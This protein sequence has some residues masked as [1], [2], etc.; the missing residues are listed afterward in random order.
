[1]ARIRLT[2]TRIDELTCPPEKSQAFVFDET[3]PSLA[4]RVTPSG[5][6]SYVFESKLDRRT[7]RITLGSTK[8]WPLES[9]WTGK[10]KEREEV[11]RGARE[12]AQRLATLVDQGID[13]R[14]V[15]QAKREAKVAAETAAEAA[16]KY[17]LA[18]LFEAYAA[19]IEKA[20]KKGSARTARSLFS[21]HA[22]AK[23]TQTP[24]KDVSADD[25]ADMLRAVVEAGK[26]RTAGALRTYMLAAFNVGMRARFDPLL[27][28]AFKEYGIT[29]N[30]VAAIPAIASREHDR[31]LTNDELKTYVTALGDS[32]RDKALLLA[33]LAGGQ[34][35][36]QVLRIKVTD[37]D[38][39]TKTLRL[40]DPKGRR[41]KARLHLLPLA[42]RAAALVDSLLAG[43]DEDGY[44]LPLDAQTPGKRAKAICMEA[45]IAP[46]FNLRDIRRTAETRMAGLGISKDT[47]AHVL[48]HGIGGVQDKHYDRHSYEAEKRAA[49]LAWENW[50]KQ[51]ETGEKAP[52]NVVAIHEAAA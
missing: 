24:A 3:V 12:E 7:I 42:P 18:A 41:K 6:K 30:P 19:H 21:C 22:P 29:A 39:D 10:G 44:L 36:E 5:A 20:G 8:R 25:I 27:P 34:R 40:L 43:A 23:L 11:T 49:L 50:I 46:A 31:V 17:T 48:S 33:L 32:R 52:S 26:E 16:K 35:M 28:V 2:P 45:G 15:A 4:V 9:V 14:E 1:M 47:R 38:K 51:I 13:P 37:W